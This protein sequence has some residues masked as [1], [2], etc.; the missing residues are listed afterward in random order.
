[1]ENIV[2][3]GIR[4]L[5]RPA[6]S[7]SLY[8]LS[9]PG[10]LKKVRHWKAV[11][12]AFFISGSS[13]FAWR[14]WIKVWKSSLEKVE[15]WSRF[16]YWLGQA[17]RAAEGWGSQNV[18]RLSALRIGRLYPQERVL[19]LISVRGWVDPR[20]LVQPE[21]LSEFLF[22]LS[23]CFISTAFPWL[24]WHCRLF[25]HT[26]NTNTHASGGIRTR[27]RSKRSAAVL[28]LRPLS[29]WNRTRDLPACSAVPRPTEPPPTPALY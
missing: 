11:F 29:H 8:R 7:E 5:D 13:L 23:L 26:Q 12:C 17:H 19:V 6:T 2:S 9:Y 27:N 14:E 18:V 21:G 20:A 25:L 16:R 24:S 10:P 28:R 3:V 4:S 22:V 15:T 1:M